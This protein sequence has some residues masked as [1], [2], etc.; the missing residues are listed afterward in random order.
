MCDWRIDAELSRYRERRIMDEKKR[1]RMER[2]K[3][4]QRV[5]EVGGING[6]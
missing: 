6:N 4:R 3:W 5:I 2:I 1:K